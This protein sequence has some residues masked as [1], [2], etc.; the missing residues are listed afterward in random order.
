M[1]RVEPVRYSRETGNKI[2]YVR[3]KFL[4]VSRGRRVTVRTK[5]SSF[6]RSTRAAL[7]CSLES[8]REDRR[9]PLFRSQLSRVRFWLALFFHPGDSVSKSASTREPIHAFAISYRS[10]TRGNRFHRACLLPRLPFFLG[11][12]TFRALYF[13]GHDTNHVRNNGIDV[14][15]GKEIIRQCLDGLL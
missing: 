5:V 14:D 15:A 6:S 3:T 8:E 12:E 7:R 11:E 9:R 13:R 1:E 4:G 10:L 2:A